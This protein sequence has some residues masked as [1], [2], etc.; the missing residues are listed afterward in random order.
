MT[1]GNDPWFAG[2]IDGEGCFTHYTAGKGKP[3]RP[4]FSIGMRFADLPILLALRAEF[5][6][7]IHEHSTCIAKGVPQ[8]GRMPKMAWKVKGKADLERLVAYLD[9][10]PLRA[11]K[12]QQFVEWRQRFDL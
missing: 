9:R 3:A 7:S 6:G 2:F 12:A 11:A 8:P 5:G 10:F 4:Q 1:Y